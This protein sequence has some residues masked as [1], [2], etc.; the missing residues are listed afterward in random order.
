M[1]HD[2]ILRLADGLAAYRSRSPH[3]VCRWATGDGALYARLSRGRA[4]TTHRAARVIQ[5][6]SDH[7]PA[8]LPWPSD[9]PRPP[10][11]SKEAA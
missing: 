10:P 3:T 7:W 4:I 2:F 11:N 8:D 9:I 1:S 6:F 5:W